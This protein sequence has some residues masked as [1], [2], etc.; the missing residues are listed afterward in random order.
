MEKYYISSKPLD[1]ETIENI[2][3]NNIQIDL[4]EKAIERINH[5]RHY[6]DEKIKIIKNPF[7]VLQPALVHCVM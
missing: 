5:C 2:L 1:F 3:K 7:T 6:L 4:S